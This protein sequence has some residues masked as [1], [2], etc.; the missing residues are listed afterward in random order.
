MIIERVTDTARGGLR[1]ILPR[2]V[3]RWVRRRR[4]LDP[5]DGLDTDFDSFRRLKPVRRN[6]GYHAGRCV[7]RYYIENFLS[8]HAEDIRGEVLEIGDREY[9]RR[10]GRHVT[11]SEVLHAADGNP[12]ATLV[13]DLADAPGILS[14]RF[15][16]IIL[17]QTL[18]FIYDLRAA[19]RTVHR[20]LK[21]GGCALV[22]VPGI[23]QISRYDR[24]AWGELWRFTPQSAARL[25]E[26]GFPDGEVTVDWHGNVMVTV[27]FL[28]GLVCDELREEEFEFRD[29][30]YPLIITVRAK[31]AGAGR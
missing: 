11:R 3:V 20:I 9:T 22:T 17:T 19:V 26:E 30:D 7:D 21:P 24:D 4:R 12:E 2:P 16:C 27:A 10:F 18:E 8:T 15:D 5:S 28:H 23:T 31:K 1:A 14:N 29:P 6:F 13:A 25:F